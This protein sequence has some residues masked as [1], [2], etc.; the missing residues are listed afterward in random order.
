MEPDR[1]RRWDLDYL[2]LAEFWARRKS[3]DPSTKVC[4][5]VVDANNDVAALGYNGFP[6]GVDDS[7]ERYADRA[8]KYSLVVHAEQNALSIAEGRSRGGTIYIWPLFSCNECAKIVIQRGIRRVVSPSPD[9]TRWSS[10][11]DTALLMYKEAGVQVDF[12]DV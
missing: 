5:V 10:A 1:Q 7:P 3:K 11:Y 8:V 9:N 2:A 4:A 12:V 6:K